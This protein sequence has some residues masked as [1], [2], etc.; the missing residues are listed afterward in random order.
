MS[1]RDKV[2][3]NIF[4]SSVLSL[5]LTISFFHV[6]EPTKPLA[7]PDNRT[8]G[9]HLNRDM[10][11][12]CYNLPCGASSTAIGNQETMASQTSVKKYLFP[13]HSLG[14]RLSD[15]Y[16]SFKVAVK[17]ALFLNRTIVLV[18]FVDD[19]AGTAANVVPFNETYS[20]ESLQD[21]LPVATMEE[22]QLRCNYNLE[23]VVS[24]PHF[25]PTVPNMNS[26]ESSYAKERQQILDI[27]SV[28]APG[29]ESVSKSQVDTVRKIL[30]SQRQECFGMYQPLDFNYMNIEKGE[31]LDEIVEA[32]FVRAPSIRL[33]ARTVLRNMCENR[34]IVAVHW[35]SKLDEICTDKSAV[36]SSKSACQKKEEF[37]L[38][39]AS[40]LPKAV[41]KL[42]EA[43]DLQCIYVSQPPSIKRG[44]VKYLSPRIPK[45]YSSVDVIAMAN[46]LSHKPS[47]FSDDYFLSL[48]EQEI[49]DK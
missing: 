29:T 38:K 41:T 43:Y 20:V 39:S 45:V 26:H 15:Q 3:F 32:H 4:L 23:V 49:C 42:L 46:K 11:A 25:G 30:L 33:A 5:V 36:I 40:T 8:Q 28:N 1:T 10:L 21:I 18:P 44:I 13:M 37:L 24:A 14:L 7:T 6:Y 16:E 31:E 47:V 12:R 48:V 34:P 9:L 27:F 35:R 19:S 17:F 22:F 2:I